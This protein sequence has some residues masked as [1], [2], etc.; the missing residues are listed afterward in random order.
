[1]T[2]T[3][4][5]YI[6]QFEH[7]MWQSESHS[8]TQS[9]KFVFHSARILFAVLRDIF[10]GY[11]TLHAMS[12]VFTSLLAIVPFLALAFSLLKAIGY[13]NQLEPILLTWLEPLGDQRAVIIDNVISAISNMKVGVLGTL[14]G[15]LFLYWV[16]SLVQKV[17]RSFNEVWKVSKSRSL[18]QRFSNYL[19]VII[20]GPVL[21]MSAVGVTTAIVGSETFTHLLDIAPIGWLYSFFLR[22]VPYIIVIALFTFLYV[23]IPNTKVK[24]RYALA[25][26]VTAGIMWQTAVLSFAIVVSNTTY[27]A[28]YAGLAVGILFLF[29]L[30]ISWLILL[31]GASVSFYAQHAQQIT[32]DRRTPSSPRI[33][34]LT[35]LALVN[36]VAHQFDQG[37]G[38]PLIEI[39]STMS[40]G[41][42]IIQRIVDKLI[43]HKI[44]TLSNNGECLIPAQS[45]DKI[46]L[47]DVI[48][49][50]RA[51]D[52]ALPRSL[53]SNTAVMNLINKMEQKHDEVAADLTIAQW[54]RTHSHPAT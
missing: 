41:P 17:D 12:L 25:G 7:W 1:M 14:G 15:G 16:I 5:K 27:F 37:G 9:G 26:G 3:L 23:F 8:K 20:V 54:I 32:K 6:K 47:K 51:P 53:T 38:V 33:D 4:E 19:S 21:V 50:L 13:Q 36:R 35:G 40:V 22:L 48:R 11:I 52:I 45:M 24:I 43:N 2:A 18:A 10:Q 44:L 34:E 30:Y 29:W 28:I 39:E 42:E 31:I 46:L 49:I